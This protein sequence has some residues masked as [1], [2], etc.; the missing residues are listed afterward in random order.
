MPEE[1]SA[2]IKRFQ[3]WAYTGS[4]LLHEE[5]I[6]DTPWKELVRLYLFA[7]RFGI[8]N[9]QNAV[10]DMLV[11]KEHASSTT[12]TKQLRLI[13]DNTPSTSPL[14]RYM[15]DVSAQL[16]HLDRWFTAPEAFLGRYPH[17]FLL[18]LAVEQYNLLKKRSK[19]HDRK[20][21]GCTYHVHPS[22]TPAR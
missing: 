19:T 3:L 11:A 20:A 9:M 1:T 7:E 15:V 10:I 16:G 2:V 4:P 8:P 17:A 22:T 6:K 18:E 13:Y 5:V 12:P 21:L 14:R